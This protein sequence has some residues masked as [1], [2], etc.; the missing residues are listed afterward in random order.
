MR[1]FATATA[2]AALFVAMPAVAQ[3]QG[4]AQQQEQQ[5]QSQPDTAE[6]QDQ[7][8]EQDTVFA[9]QAYDGNLVQIRLG[10]IAQEQAETQEV[11][12][13]GKRMAAEHAKANDELK[14]ILGD[15]GLEK[16]DDMPDSV[17]ETAKNFE[18]MGGQELGA[19]YMDKMLEVHQN[20]IDLYN[21]AIKDVENEDLKSYAE[22][23]LPSL[24]EHLK[25]AERISQGAGE[26]ASAESKDA[27]Q[28]Q[29]AEAG[30]AG[31]DQ[32]EQMAEQTADPEAPMAGQATDPAMEGTDQTAEGTETL[33]NL[34]GIVGKAV[35]GSDDEQVG[36][37]SEV[38]MDG[39]GNAQRV[40]ID[41]G[42]F[43]GIGEK[44]IAIELDRL[45]ITDDRVSVDMTDEQIAE[46]PEYEAE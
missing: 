18:G 13:F 4:G 41:R 42:G 27:E 22:N 3:E 1:H 40:V 43:L 10:K 20:A 28:P 7:A 33:P 44:H 26:M 9:E 11:K 29:Q 36:E 2:I 6:S 15:M 46:I 38:L 8:A 14:G 30:G 12:D 16:S 37:V 39:S 31:A 32:A 25:E 23:T 17:Q 19:A 5:Q 21:A 24:E 45:T 35:Y 34:D